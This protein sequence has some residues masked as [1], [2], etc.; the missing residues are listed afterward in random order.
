MTTDMVID[1]GR[2]AERTLFSGILDIYYITSIIQ[3]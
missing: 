3:H 1:L 2:D